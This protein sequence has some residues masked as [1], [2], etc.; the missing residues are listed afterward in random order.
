[1][2][3]FKENKE[4]TILTILTFLLSFIVY[5][6][7]MSP[8]VSFWDCG[9]FIATSFT[10]A[11]PHPPGSPL[12]LLIGRFFSMI[13]TSS[14][15]AFR[16]NLMSP[17]VSAFAVMFLFLIIIQLLKSWGNP[18][19]PLHKMAVYAGAFVGAMT[20][21][22]SDSHWFNAV[23]AEVYAFS[24]FLTAIV[25]WLTLVWEEK[26]DQ[27]GHERYLLIIAYIMGL[28][29]G[30]HLLNLL[31]IFFIALIIYFKRTKI[32]S[33]WWLVADLL[34]G[35]A[36]AGLIFLFFL[37]LKV[38]FTIQALLTF[39]AF[40][41]IYIPLYRKSIKP[42]L[43]EHAQNVLMAFS[44]SAVFLVIN[45]GVIRGLPT[46][47]DKY[48]LVVLA[49]AIFAVFGVTVWAIVKKHNLLSLGLMCLVLIIIGYSSYMTIF[50]R[51]AQDPRIDEN[52]PETTH[53]AVAYLEREQYGERSFTDIFDRAKWKP[54]AEYK[55]KKPGV[56]QSKATWNYFWN[57]QINYMY[58]R[59]FNWQFIGR[60]IDKVN[61]W[62]FFLPFPFL[63]GIYGLMIHFGKDRNKALSVLALFL[64]TGLMIVLYLNQDD[65]QPRERDYS[66]VGSFFAF[67]IW[68]GIGASALISHL[69][70]LK[71]EKL[72]KPLTY[73]CAALLILVLPLNILRA[74]YHEHSRKG[75]FVAW[76]YSYN[77]L[78]TCEKD[79]VIFTNGD[80]DT[81]PLWYLQEVEGIRRD[82]KVV[83][84]SL[85]NTPWY[86]KQLR[87][88][89]PKL[90]LGGMTDADIDNLGVI[91]WKK[92]EVRLTPP[93]NS[94]LP[95]LK[96]ELDPTIMGQGLRVQDIM[97]MQLLEA[98]KWQRPFY[99]AVT[100]SQDNKLNM[101]PFLQMEGLAFRI[102]PQAVKRV[103]V[104]K[105]EHN[106]NH[107]YR[108]RNL[109]NPNVYFDDNIVKLVGNYRSGYFQLAVEK[110]YSSDRMMQKSV[111]G[112]DNV[113]PQLTKDKAE[114]AAI[115]DSMETK[116]PENVLPIGNKEIYL[117][118]GMLY[119]EGGRKE[120]LIR[121]LNELM[122]MPKQTTQDKIRYASVFISPL[123]DYTAALE[124]LEPLENENKNSPDIAG[125][126]VKAYEEMGNMNGAIRVLDGWLKAH[127]DDQGAAAMKSTY[128]AKK[129][130]SKSAGQTGKKG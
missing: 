101:D 102:H 24:T 109:N 129:K 14:D 37:N 113:S 83:N 94:S 103:S 50:I 72:R 40:L 126:L 120:E 32:S 12:Y 39:A 1:M 11:V 35:V 104:E 79:G 27:P 29:T 54:E 26:S 78:Q 4:K 38:S 85:L 17:I 86:I 77:I 16:V 122:A 56:S 81:F 28:A 91:P 92:T 53:Q 65:P 90:S 75:N 115:L 96:W 60:S 67:A 116:L 22:Y 48:G 88:I 74:N 6:D 7:T 93:P 42:R 82:V 31:A 80:N 8:T 49:L 20:F 63:I 62:Q 73:A 2:S 123:K 112:R 105:L 128:E 52:D 51:S 68:I 121:R 64:F 114:L 130:A 47:A 15:I 33:I 100:V 41:G 57:Y 84:L 110:L 46:I 18:H 117:Q 69:S 98:N 9:E 89:E 13:P 124:I 125:L 119:Y 118:L 87:D 45:G 30:I 97:I 10:L 70:N 71:N 108:Y 21:A 107:V 55:Y 34:I 111:S 76:D 36:A 127:P 5:F 99:Y 23:E 19:Q 106:L 66:Y 44:A 25:V 59:Y 3:Y 61:P 58:V 43:R 95:P